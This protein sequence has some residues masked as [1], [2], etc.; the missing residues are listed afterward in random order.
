MKTYLAGIV[1]YG[2]AQVPGF[3]VLATLGGLMV[4]GHHHKWKVP[5][6]AELW[7]AGAAPGALGRR[8]KY[9][10]QASPTDAGSASHA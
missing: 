10:R 5:R 9:R 1:R 2:L 6:F 3:L 4:W 7:G 8:S